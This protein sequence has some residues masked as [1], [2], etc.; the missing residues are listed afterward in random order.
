MITA[1]E[2]P[3]LPRD[4]FVLLKAVVIGLALGFVVVMLAPYVL[5][6][7][8][9]KSL[10][11]QG[12]RIALLTPEGASI[13]DAPAR[14]HRSAAATVAQPD[15]LGQDGLGLAA[16]GDDNAPPAAAIAEDAPKQTQKP[17]PALIPAVK[18]EF[19]KPFSSDEMSAA[20]APVLS[21]KLGDDDAAALKQLVSA[22]SRNNGDAAN[23]ALQKIKDPAARTFGEWKRTRRADAD[24]DQALAFSHAHP[25]FPVP[26]Q[27]ASSE[28]SLFLSDATPADVLRFYSNRLPLTSAGTA[29]FGGALLETGQRDRGLRLIKFAWSRYPFDPAVQERFTAKFGSLL[30][31]GDQR[32]RAL[33]L[34]AREKQKDDP[35]SIS[36]NRGYRSVARLKARS[37]HARYFRAKAAARP[38]RR[39]VRRRGRRAK[40]NTV[41]PERETLLSEPA[42]IRSLVE[43]VQLRKAMQDSGASKDRTDAKADDTKSSA[44]ATNGKQDEANKTGRQAKAA[45]NAFNLRREATGGPATLLARLKSL[46]RENADDDV[47]SLLRS[48]DPNKADLADPDRWWSFRR[49]EIRRALDQDRPKTAYGI[50]SVHGPL[51]DET[52]SEAEFLAG[53]IALQFL[54]DPKTAEP[55]FRASLA[56]KGIVRDEARAA[57]WLG[58]AQLA[59]GSR[60]AAEAS[61]TEAASRFYTFYG[62]LA[63]QALRKAPAC[64]FRAPPRPTPEA[65][66]AFANEPAFKAVAIIKQL[67]N[68]PLLVSF[69]LDLARQVNDPQQ[70]MLLLE[71]TERV[72]PP[73][74]AVRAA[75]IAVLRGL[76]MEA[77]AYPALLPKFDSTAGSAKLE[78]ALINALTRQ[79][80]EFHTGSV[81]P[82][83]AR[84]LMQL[85][86]QTARLVAAENKL[87][88]ELPRLINDPSYNVT[89][90]SAFLASLLD[91]YDGSYILALAAYNA[92]PGRVKQWIKEFG[93][94]RDKD[95]DPIDWIERIPIA[96]TKNY[97]QRILESV[98]L[99]RCRF[100]SGKAK[101]Q[102]LEDLHRGRPGKL[103]DFDDLSGS[104]DLDSTP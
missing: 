3:K 67:D 15:T 55:H 37:A 77:Y 102:I 62:A 11:A 71:L 32:R 6:L 92:G 28:R 73:H 30:D 56:A 40:L 89:L 31:E 17:E 78:L 41:V 84:G 60:R 24:F 36:D 95:V 5:P 76:P 4:P 58:R 93:D 53:W 99:Y 86:P 98:Q 75:K 33:L 2:N 34:A 100:E 22:V 69:V 81:S 7:G 97:V 38:G 9:V 87:K 19:P 88:Y 70:M 64:E 27:D 94:P 80:S 43:R 63:K 44:H 26:A 39:V 104:G 12:T 72:A 29:S 42:G 57:Y 61:F 49:A 50:A 82:V 8:S 90:G 51:E 35:G 68:E 46:R 83:G 23:D 79:E 25:L 21:F 103:P 101:F 10:T 45:E 14:P 85:M 47:W 48:V 52:L 54:N 66:A 1:P 20:L 18:L 74:V 65:I 91:G 96:E 16:P 13:P 59:Q